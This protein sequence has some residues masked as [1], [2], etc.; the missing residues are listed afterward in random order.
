MKLFT[1]KSLT[2]LAAATVMTIAIV[3]PA[4]SQVTIQ[5]RPGGRGN[6]VGQVQGGQGQGGGAKAKKDNA[7]MKA[8]LKDVHQAEQLMKKGLPIY[9][10][11]RHMAMAWDG[12]AAAEIKLGMAWNR[13]Q[14][15]TAGMQSMAAKKNQMNVPPE[16]AKRKYTDQE[17]ADSN[18]KLLQASGLL[19][20]A[21][22]SLISAPHEYGGHRSAAVQAVDKSLG[23][24]KI[25]LSLTTGNRRG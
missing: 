17:I 25:A 12:V 21:R 10:G 19:T 20:A 18:A 5:G 24:I 13:T 22:Q 4:N 1:T 14:P 11:H 2:T 6:H 8:A 23:E 15:D 16:V 3:L 7:A 9:Q